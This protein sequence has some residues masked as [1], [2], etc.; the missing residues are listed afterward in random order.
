M[1]VVLAMADAA[2]PLW[3]QLQLQLQLAP[4]SRLAAN[5]QVLLLQLLAL[6][7]AARRGRM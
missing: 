5:L 7:P 6:I 4:T 1:L 2:S 3:L